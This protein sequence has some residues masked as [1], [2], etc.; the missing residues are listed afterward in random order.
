MR[1]S[2]R[3]LSCLVMVGFCAAVL[4]QTPRGGGPRAKRPKFDKS[5][6]VFFDDLFTKLVGERPTS[7]KGGS[8]PALA[9]GAPGR[10]SESPAAAGKQYAWSRIISASTIED[11]IKAIKL[12]LD[13]NVTTPS[14]FAGRGHKPVR[15]DLSMAAMLFAVIGEFDGEVRWKKDAAS[16]RDLFARTAANAKAGGNAQVYNE[17]KLRKAD[18][19]DLLG[20]NTPAA[21]EAEPNANWP[22]VCDRSPLMQRLEESF[23]VKIAPLTANKDEFTKHKD[24]LRHEA[25]LLAAISDVLNKEG[26]QDADDAT[27]RGFADAMKQAGL[28]IVDAIKL[29]NYDKSR[30]ATGVITKACSACHE[31]YRG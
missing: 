18:L 5:T 15:R 1:C 21:K 9:S 17:A 10:N 12:A 27:Y 7:L 22:Q 24:A 23:D 30:E 8:V 6:D 29:D 25:E 2:I 31:S 26:M 13:K 3:W 14:D 4:A 16:V 20:G 11:E 28:D 19:T